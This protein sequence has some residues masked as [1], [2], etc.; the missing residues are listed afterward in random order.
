MASNALQ[1]GSREFTVD[2]FGGPS[3]SMTF[4]SGAIASGNAFLVGELEKRNMRLLEP[5]K[6]IWWPRDLFPVTGGGLVEY[7]SQMYVD[8]AAS[9]GTGDFMG[10]ETNDIATIQASVSKD[11]WR[12]FTY[13][14]KMRIPFVDQQRMQMIGRSLNQILDDGVRLHQNKRMDLTLYK[15]F[16]AANIPGLVNNSNV[17][18]VM[19]ATGASG[20]TTWAKKTPTEILNDINTIL[21]TTWA[22]SGYDLTGMAN[23]ILVPVPQYSLLQQTVSTAG[24]V[25]ILKYVLENNIRRNQLGEDDN[26][27]IGPLPYC[28]G[29]GTG[30][31]DRMVGYVNAENRLAFDFTQPL[32]SAMTQ[33]D[34]NQAAY[35]TLFLSAWSQVRFMYPQSVL[36]TDGV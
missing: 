18:T 29:A 16:P 20:S 15:G 6:S 3:L 13:P 36:Y 35:I 34:A 26:I 9:G 28:A 27:F 12:V 30:A 24:N 5:L 32:F 23:H 10:G 31:T 19:A 4:D 22:N 14:T 2:G 11:V 1:V 7:V 8:Y 25:S 17:T 21:Y 33:P